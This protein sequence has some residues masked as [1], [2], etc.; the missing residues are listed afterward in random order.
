MV[1]ASARTVT[2]AL[3]ALRLSGAVAMAASARAR[4]AAESKMS[5]AGQ[6]SLSG[7]ALVDCRD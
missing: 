5:D 2:R 7:A 3:R 1:C 6:I 4:T